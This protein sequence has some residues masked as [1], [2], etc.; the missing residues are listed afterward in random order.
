MKRILSIFGIMMLLSFAIMALA[1]ES[2]VK[3]YTFGDYRYSILA[4]GTVKI[5]EYSGKDVELSIPDILENRKVTSIG[6][7]AFAGINLRSVTL[8]NSITSIGINPFCNCLFLEKI[9]ISPDHPIFVTIDDVLYSMPERK[10]LSYPIKKNTSSFSIPKGIISIGDYAFNLC[11]EITNVIIPESITSIGNNA[12]S[13]CKNLKT[14]SIPNGVQS[15][16]EFSFSG[17]TNLRNVEISNSVTSIG[18]ASFSFCTELSQI[19]LPNN[20]LSIEDGT[21]S[22]CEKITSITLPDSV[23]KIGKIAFAFCSSLTSIQLPNS[24]SYIESDSFSGCPNLTL[25]V[26]RNSYSADYC[27][28]KNLKYSYTDN[29]DWLNN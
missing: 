1:E 16:G 20:L 15:I 3:V 22:F 29:L 13:G 8:P 4:D 2:E 6:D 10:L 18:K 9:Y 11:N 21:F 17:C 24:I 5:L 19:N 23:T 26:P 28:E 7:Q 12:F 14:V 27:K 25:T